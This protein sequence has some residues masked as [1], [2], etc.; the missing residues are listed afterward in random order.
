[1]FKLTDRFWWPVDLEVPGDGQTVKRRIELEF[2]RRS[3][4]ELDALRE[5]NKSDAAI[6]ADVVLGW[7]NVRGDDDQDL[8]FTPANFQQLLRE[9]AGSRL[10]IVA[11]YFDAMLG[12]ARRKNLSGL[13]GIG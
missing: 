9:V 1:M 8:T 5:S 10:T 2:K 12:A 6:C 3:Q 4:G 7:K 13:R 11:T